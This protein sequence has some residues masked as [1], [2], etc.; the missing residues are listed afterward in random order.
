LLLNTVR[1]LEPAMALLGIVWLL[2]LVVDFTHGLSGSLA[3]LNRAIW[4]IFVI[5]FMAEFV[6]APDKRLYLERHWLAAVSLAVPAVRVVRLARLVRVARATRLARG[7]RLL[8]T[9]AS[10]NRALVSLRATSRRRGAGYVAIMTALVTLGGAAGMYVFERGV[11]DPAGIHDYGTAI[12][13]TAMIMTTMGSAYW[14]QTAEGRILCV[15]LALYAFA[16]FGYVTATLAT[17]FVD[18]DADTDDAAIAGQRAIEALRSDISQLRQEI[19]F[20][21]AG[22]SPRP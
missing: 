12:W 15:V 11:P 5:D 10:M 7:A 22:D 17:F 14:P 19:A 9:L 18:R 1:T 3:V 21:R 16:V 4:V 8:R 2:L 6:I 13:W 20:R